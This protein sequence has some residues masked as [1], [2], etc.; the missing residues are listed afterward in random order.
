[1]LKLDFELIPNSLAPAKSYWGG[2]WADI[3][4]GGGTRWIISDLGPKLIALDHILKYVTTSSD[5]NNGDDDGTDK[6]NILCPLVGSDL[7]YHYAWSLGHTVTGIDLIPLALER[8]R[9][10]FGPDESDW[11]QEEDE[12]NGMV[13]WKHK[14]GK[15]T[16]YQGDVFK[17]LEDLS[18]SF[19]VLYDKD[20]F[21]AIPK[22]KRSEFCD[23]VTEYLKDGGIVY[24]EVKFKDDDHP[25]RFDGPP[26]HLD[27]DEL[28][29]KA[30]FGKSF[31]YLES[32]GEVYEFY[33]G[34]SKAK[35]TGHVMKRIK[36]AKR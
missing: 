10:Q 25:G 30:N 17:P 29:D 31:E 5:N 35:Q 9:K 3:E 14:S 2:S 8:M 22:H 28:M 21:G 6:L 32:L 15:A 33:K 7:F 20:S 13:I 16:L 24:T 18:D 19:D 11:T 23:R 27:K 1:M 34:P 4:A 26:F 12:V 36:T